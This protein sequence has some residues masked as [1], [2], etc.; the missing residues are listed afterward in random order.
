MRPSA[1]LFLK[2]KAQK[3]LS[4]KMLFIDSTF[5]WPTKPKK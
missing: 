5:I 4:S 1:H 3:K 2:I